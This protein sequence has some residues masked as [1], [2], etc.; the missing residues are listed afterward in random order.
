MVNLV[1]INEKSVTKA[2]KQ[3]IKETLESVFKYTNEVNVHAFLDFKSPVDTL[4]IY[5]Y[6]FFIEIPYKKGNY[7]RTQ[8]K[9]YLNNIVFAIRK[10]TDTTITNIK[11]N[12]IY[13]STGEFDYNEQ[14]N[15]ETEALK[16]YIRT[17]ITNVNYVDWALYY[18]LEAPNC[19]IKGWFGNLLCN[20]PCNIY[21]LISKTV[22]SK[23]NGK[24]TTCLRFK[25]G[26]KLSDAIASFIE[27]CAACTGHG[28]LTK[29]KM[30]AISTKEIGKQMQTLYDSAGKKL[31][32]ITG[33]A[34][35]GKSLALLRF[36]FNH[37]QKH[38]CRLLTFNNLL[39]MDTK[40]AL[41]NLGKFTP[42]N[43]SISTLHKFFYELYIHTP[44]CLL[45]MNE[46]QINR[47]FALC[48]KRVSKM[49][50]L[51]EKYSIENGFTNNADTILKY[52][53][54]KN[55]VN[56]L[57]VKEM[58]YFASYLKEKGNWQLGEL[59]SL[60][61][62]YV[63]KKR[64]RFIELYG[65]RAFLNGYRIIM[66]QLF[67]LYHNSKDFFDKFGED[68]LNA[69]MSV[70]Q[71]SEFNKEDAKRYDEFIEQCKD[72]FS[73]EHGIPEELFTQYIV[74]EEKLINQ[75]KDKF[76]TKLRTEQIEKTDNV[77]KTVKQKV[78]WS[79][80]VLVDEAQDC[81]NYEKELLLEL[82]GSKN[83]IIASGGKDQL[84]RTA[85]ETRWDVSY[86][87]IL[88]SEKVNLTHISHRQKGN[89]A[90]FI[91]I[92]AKEFHLNTQLSVPENIKGLGK[93][94]IDLRN[95]MPPA[96]DIIKNMVAHGADYGCSPY[97]SMMILLPNEGF[98]NVSSNGNVVTIDKNNTI[99][100][101]EEDKTRK[102]AVSFPEDITILDCTINAKAQLLKK[103]GHDKTRCLLYES[104]RGLEA[105]SVLCIEL[106]KFFDE[107]RTCDAA[108]DYADE[109]LGLFKDDPVQRR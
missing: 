75:I 102:L 105:W 78:H 23:K 104:C 85:V 101:E 86:G 35:T 55:I 107:M 43:A 46:D 98:T 92:F 64:K 83:V 91:N 69:P 96:P 74:D 19:P 36:M 27:K 8:S 81:A 21:Q 89:I 15:N 56:S 77:A 90:E 14:I 13:T 82:F 10:I 24:G 45:H 88:D 51:I 94:I 18:L 48:H 71:S 40:I 28:I 3:K 42:T 38:H 60:A 87:N 73:E 47:L 52:Y 5:N 100:F 93:V 31:E 80:F 34:G 33:K 29:K 67:L 6:L 106:D 22:D 16:S 2:D 97:E 84:I 49:V 70:R 76:S 108:S 57:D 62:D 26:V 59:H 95:I 72:K 25:E 7:F 11:G 61:I 58:R 9:V 54:D 12:K 17:N 50:V 4:G 99:S 41:R 109:A 20:I 63:H 39:V 44:V 68:L 37:V 53:E 66:E 1:I 32:I 65:Y 79:K 103:V 30:D